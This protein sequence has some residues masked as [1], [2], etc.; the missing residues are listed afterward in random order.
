MKARVPRNLS[1]LSQKEIQAVVE[2]EYEKTRDE[3]AKNFSVGF[4][5]A[6]LYTKFINTNISTAKLKQEFYDLKSTF[7]LMRTGFLGVS[8]GIQDCVDW[9]KKTLDIDLEKEMEVEVK[10]IN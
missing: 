2:S 3:H 1:N 5:S 9:V 6:I 10:T 7:E 8:F 4:I